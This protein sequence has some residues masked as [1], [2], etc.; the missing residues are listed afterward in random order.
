MHPYKLETWKSPA[1]H[2]PGFS[3]LCNVEIILSLSFFF[4]TFIFLFC[5]FR[6][7]FPWIKLSAVVCLHETEYKIIPWNNP[8]I[9][10]KRKLRAR[11]IEITGVN[12]SICMMCKLTGQYC[13]IDILGLDPHTMCAQQKSCSKGIMTLK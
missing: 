6:P 10:T 1:G 8:K 2:A 11:L 9:I 7:P 3:E 13:A 12:V 4:A 5:Y